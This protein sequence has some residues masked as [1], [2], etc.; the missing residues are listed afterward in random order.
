MVWTCSVLTVGITRSSMGVN[1][2]NHGKPGTDSA[3]RRLCRHR[4][5]RNRLLVRRQEVN[6]ARGQGSKCLERSGSVSGGG[7][8]GK[9]SSTTEITFYRCCDLWSVITLVLRRVT[10]F[11][12]AGIFGFS[13]DCPAAQ[14]NV[15]VD[16]FY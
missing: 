5:P 7:C 3:S 9:R 2:R 12:S 1:T 10:V 13:E 8:R 11:F 15:L 6:A 14:H 16:S 4:H